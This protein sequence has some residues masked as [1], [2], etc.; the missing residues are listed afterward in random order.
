[1]PLGSFR[2]LNSSGVLVLASG[3]RMG[4]CG[5]VLK[6]D[7]RVLRDKGKLGHLNRWGRGWSRARV[8]SLA[9]WQIRDSVSPSYGHF[10]PG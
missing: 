5:P 3:R 6:D 10:S 8:G 4:K 9:H 7:L 1:M 2:I